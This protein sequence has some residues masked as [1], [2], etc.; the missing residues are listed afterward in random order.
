MLATAKLIKNGDHRIDE[1]MPRIAAIAA[2]RLFLISAFSGSAAA[3]MENVPILT[4]PPIRWL[5]SCIPDDAL[6]PSNVANRFWVFSIGGTAMAIDRITVSVG[7]KQA[8]IKTN[9][10]ELCS[11]CHEGQSPIRIMPMT[12]SIDKIMNEFLRNLREASKR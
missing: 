12:A 11:S 1:F 4:T 5:V 9:S 8:K 10:L 7:N 2:S 6:F 3:I